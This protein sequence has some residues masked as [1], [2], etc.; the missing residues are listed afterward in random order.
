MLMLYM[1]QYDIYGP[2]QVLQKFG[3]NFKNDF[4]LKQLHG[5]YYMVHI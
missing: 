1:I 5:K 2:C 3:F 4:C